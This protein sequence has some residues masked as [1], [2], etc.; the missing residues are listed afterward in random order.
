[1]K[2]RVQVTAFFAVVAVAIATTSW[3][4]SQMSVP[5]AAPGVWKVIRNLTAFILLGTCVLEALSRWLNI[6]RLAA[7]SLLSIA[8]A[9]VTG[10]IWPLIVVLWIALSCHVIGNAVVRQLKLSTD[11]QIDIQALL[12]GALAYGTAVGLAAHFPINHPGVYGV[13]LA[14]PVLIGWQGICATARSL[15]QSIIQPSRFNMLDSMIGLIAIMHFVVALMPEVGHDALAMHLFI[16]GHMA[17]RHEWGFDAT[18]YS[19]AVMPMMGDWLYSLGYVL[20]GETTARLINVGFI[21]AICWLV[22]ELVL[23]AGGDSSGAKWAVLLLLSTPLTYT[24]SSSLFIES[25]WAAFVVGSFLAIFRLDQN[26]SGTAGKLLLAALLLSGA[27][28]AKAVTLTILPVFA[29]VLALRV[30]AWK[31][32][33]LFPVICIATVLVVLVGGIPYLTALHFTGNPV[34]P[35]FNEI[36]ESPLY[37]NHNF[38]AS[39][40]FGKGVTWD[41]LYQITFHT[42]RFLESSPGASGFQ[43]LLLFVPA[44]L[45]L[46]LTKH[47]KGIL[48]V[49]VASASIALTF[50]SITYLRYVYPSFAWTA[51]AIG[52]AMSGVPLKNARVRQLFFALGMGVIALNLVHLRSG[53]L[54]GDIH[55]P[56]LL[57]STEREIYLASRLPIR[58]AIESVNKLN[59]ARTPVAFFAPSLAAGLVADAMHPNWYN[60]TFQFDIHQAKTA[61]KLADV[62]I[63]NNIEY[64]LFDGTWGSE[65][66]RRILQ[67]ATTVLVE[68]GPITIR[69]LKER[70][71]F[72]NELLRNPEFLSF[73]GW[74]LPKTEQTPGQIE[75]SVTSNSVQRIPAAEGQRYKNTVTALCERQNTQGRMQITWLGENSRYIKT[76]AKIFD[77]TAV[78]STH[79]FTVIA[80]RDSTTAVV[81]ATGH[82]DISL[83]FTEVSFRR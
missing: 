35:F 80:P 64:A 58:K 81:F 33:E 37:P 9:I 25:V 29:F 8:V 30:Q 71:L 52:L 77:C 1:M 3:G 62:F 23:W 83:V 13:A 50:Q 11:C 44:F 56:A 72:R 73:E 32:R 59:V 55:S 68:Q 49:A 6:H 46:C 61:N 34:F 74:S 31:K 5:D 12:L 20:A 38:D 60:W 15:K 2:T 10:N 65:G 78:A 51:A 40:T 36:F 16:P 21:F 28:A 47:R 69:V 57:S 42:G 63:K 45:I 66:Q 39:A 24:E 48:L 53:T 75:V 14:L 43:W 27:L 19:W 82:T 17:T 54:N 70:F 79:Q 26:A 18:I 22:R 4:I 7:A 41:V 76:D 67:E